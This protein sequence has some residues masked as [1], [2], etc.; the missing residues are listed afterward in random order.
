VVPL[1]RPSKLVWMRASSSSMSCFTVSSSWV[2]I[3]LF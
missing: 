3:A 1:R 2:S